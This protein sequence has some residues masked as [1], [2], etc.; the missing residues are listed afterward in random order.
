M[1]TPLKQ[2][3][4]QGGYIALVATLIVLTGVI[5]V[6]VSLSMNGVNELQLSFYER[7]SMDA[8]YLADACMNEGILR[9]KQDADSG[10]T[11]YTGG[12]L[13]D[14]LESDESCSVTVTSPDANTR[15]IQAT[16]VKSDS[17]TRLI[18]AS[19]DIS[20]DFTV[21]SWQEVEEF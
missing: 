2:S 10:Y 3:K 14:I 15:V 9:L 8:F 18:E 1:N 6:G 7:Q 21:S 12:T 11:T 13:D 17:F 5:F 19:I 16:G 4:D 20:G